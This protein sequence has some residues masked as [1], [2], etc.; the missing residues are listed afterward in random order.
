[1]GSGTSFD[2]LEKKKFLASVV[3]QTPDRSSPQPSHYTGYYI[4]AGEESQL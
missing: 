3:I 1:V 4:A 2:Y